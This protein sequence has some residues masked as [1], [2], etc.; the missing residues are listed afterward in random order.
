MYNLK[1][2]DIVA[3]KSYGND[4]HFVITNI[5]NQDDGKTIYVLKG[6]LYRIQADAEGDDLIKQNPFYTNLSIKRSIADAKRKVQL[7]NWSRGW[8]NFD[9]RLE[10]PGK[11]LHVDS[12]REFMDIC[13]RHY[14]QARINCTGYLADEDEQPDL[15]G[16]LL[17]RNKPDIIVITGH[18]G[19]KKG[20]LL[21]DSLNNYRTSKYFVQSVRE[22]RKYQPNYDKLCIFAGACQ[23]YYE[24]IMEAGANFASSPGRILINALDPA[25]VSEKVALTDSRSIVK[26][27]EVSEMTISG[28]KGIGGINTKGRLIRE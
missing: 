26:P 13:I 3:R 23:S 8:Y 20:S 12:S 14:K 11:I 19:I 9:K 18:D 27:E 10:R 16:D 25:I 24:A 15:I 5:Y 21:M 7:K 22:A 17:E 6:L 4:I 28:P 2:G 1:T